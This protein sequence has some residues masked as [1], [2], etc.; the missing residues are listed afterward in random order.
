MDEQ[1]VHDAV[2]GL[3]AFVEL[4][5]AFYDTVVTDPVLR[6]MYPTNLEPGKRYLA[7]FFAQYFGGPNA[8]YGHERGHPRLRRRHA[9]FP[10]DWD[11]ALRWATAMHQAIDQQ[12]WDAEAAAHVH[13]YV[14]RAAPMMI[15]RQ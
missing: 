14:D 6:P 8:P 3:E 13:A 4:V 12:P 11:A 2:G 15:N 9:D 10:V 7:L 5:D 1:D